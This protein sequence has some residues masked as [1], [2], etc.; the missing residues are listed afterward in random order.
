[1]F[2]TELPKFII[3]NPDILKDDNIPIIEKVN[4]IKRKYYQIY[5]YLRK[6]P[7]IP[8]TLNKDEIDK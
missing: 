2:S 5:S 6:Q 4:K 3:E 7:D 1:M 8:L